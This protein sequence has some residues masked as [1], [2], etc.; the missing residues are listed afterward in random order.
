MMGL[1][2]CTL[3]KARNG[4]DLTGGLISGTILLLPAFA[5]RASL[6]QM[7]KRSKRAS[8]TSANIDSDPRCQ[9]I[10]G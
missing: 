8:Q 7:S 6:D 10:D 5:C 1:S 9:F 4:E 3:N 2:F